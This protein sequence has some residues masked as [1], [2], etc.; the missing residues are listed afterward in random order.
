[1]HALAYIIQQPEVRR[2]VAW[3]Q[4]RLQVDLVAG[5]QPGK[6][7]MVAKGRA[8]GRALVR[9][10][11]QLRSQDEKAHR[12]HLLLGAIALFRYLFVDL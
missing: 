9:R 11:G 12:E 8:L 3:G 4:K 1:V 6:E 5:G 10:I 7:A 2:I